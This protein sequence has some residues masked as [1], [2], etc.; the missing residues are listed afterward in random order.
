MTGKK[1]A[2]LIIFIIGIIG[3]ILFLI[4]DAIGIGGATGFGFKQIIGAII[5]V[6]FIVVGSFL[7]FKK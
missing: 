3:L 5:G 6:I 7:A 4:A 1:I 2:G